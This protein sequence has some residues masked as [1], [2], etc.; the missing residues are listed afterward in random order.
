MSVGV[1]SFARAQ[2]TPVSR[3]LRFTLYAS[4][5]DNSAGLKGRVCGDARRPRC[6]AIIAAVAGNT[7]RRPSRKREGGRIRE[8]D[9]EGKSVE[10]RSAPPTL[11]RQFSRRAERRR[12]ARDFGAAAHSRGRTTQRAEQ[13]MHHQHRRDVKY[14]KC[15]A[16]A[17]S[18]PARGDV[19]TTRE[20]ALRLPSSPPPPPPPRP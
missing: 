5:T 16:A 10:V 8:E 18:L 20:T 6:S 14:R 13:L 17:G 11:T 3:G 1:L 15:I 19:R 9:G 2:L 7:A 12:D 4:R